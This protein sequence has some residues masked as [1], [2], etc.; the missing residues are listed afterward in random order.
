MVKSCDVGSLPFLN[1][2]KRFLEGA[3][4][5]GSS[6][7]EFVN[8]FERRVINGF[9]D[10]VEAGID[11]PNYPQF[12]D[13]NEMFLEM[14][15]GVERVK[16]GYLETGVLSIKEGKGSIPEVLA[17][18]RNPREIYERMGGSFKM[19]VC[20][21]GPYTLSSLF[22][23]KDKGI[24]SRL[25]HMISKIVESNLF[26]E[27]YGSVV[28]VSVD[29]PVFG[30]LDD[31]LMDRGSEARENLR[32]A[33]ESI[34]QR[35]KPKG[36]QTCMHLHNTADVLFWDVEALNLIES[37]VGDPLY[38]A[39]RT[40]E[41]LE[42]KDK[43][44][45][46]SICI[47]DFDKLIRGRVIADSP[48]KMSEFIIN[49]RVAEAWKNIKEGKLDPKTFL[50]DTELMRERLSKAINRFGA[51][52]V[53]YAGPECGLKGFPTYECAMECLRRVSDAIKNTTK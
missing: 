34:F 3:S 14:I 31:P 27:K 18:K 13:M 21:T 9:L 51:E 38:E 7:D 52:R 15:N 35:A 39:K 6:T 29:E 23:Y 53:P 41:L 40:R 22:L 10:K 45:K 5:Y 4:R 32:G 20:V 2:V 47:A 37:H 33:W 50:E 25:G 19:K 17:I 28:L 43:F 42:S 1:D 49:Q 12:R 11:V 8:Y 26:S 36:V 30:L 48:Q 16:G 24:V 44:L 46:A